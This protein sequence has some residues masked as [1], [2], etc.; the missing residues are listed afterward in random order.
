MR[1]RC[2]NFCKGELHNKSEDLGNDKYF[3]EVHTNSAR[4]FPLSVSTVDGHDKIK[5]N[6]VYCPM[7]RR[8]CRDYWWLPTVE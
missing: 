8:P 4:L 3:G 1:D 5:K 6:R 7:N 2:S